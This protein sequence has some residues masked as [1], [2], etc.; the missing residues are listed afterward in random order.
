MIKIYISLI[1]LTNNTNQ[2][3]F[4]FFNINNKKP[5]LFQLYNIFLATKIVNLT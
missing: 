4:Y 3:R 5:I 2:Y 1:K